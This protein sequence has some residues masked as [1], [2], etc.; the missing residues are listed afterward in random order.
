MKTIQEAS[1]ENKNVFIRMD[2]NVAIQNGEIIDDYKIRASLSTILDV[3]NQNPARIII[4]SHL[5]RPEGKFDERY[6]CRPI[7]NVLKKLIKDEMGEDLKFCS[8]ED[9]NNEKLV[10]IE[11]LRFYPEEQNFSKS[12]SDK[13]LS[14]FFNNYV[15]ILIVDAFGVLHRND[16]SVC[17]TGLTPYVGNLVSKEL[18]IGEDIKNEGVELIILGGCK[19]KDKI[20]ILETLIPKCK[21]VFIVGAL[22]CS[23]LKYHFRVEIGKSKIEEDAAD[24]IERIYELA[25]N[26]NVKIFVTH[27][28]KVSSNGKTFYAK[29]IP[30]DGQVVDIGMETLEQLKEVI[31]G[32]DK[33]FWNGPPGIFEND[34]SSAGS[35]NLVKILSNKQRVV[36]GG[37]ET[38]ACVRKFGKIED[39]Y[40]VSTGGGAFLKLLGNS[41]MPGVEALNK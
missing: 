36:V 2:Y 12:S 25:S 24:I 22:A 27:D 21:N 39:F 29:D 5:S 17:Y 14:S 34:E 26:H 40:H 30:K 18:S 4:G 1:I 16:Y 28:Y 31:G 20:T 8:I 15:D 11:N 19:I 41:K 23:F 6:S 9:Y 13:S 37:G 32:T 33:I 10:M 35:K 7:Y 38:A 3:I